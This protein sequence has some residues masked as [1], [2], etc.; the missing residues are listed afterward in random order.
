LV[1]SPIRGSWPE[2]N[3]CLRVWVFGVGR[4][5]WRGGGSVICHSPSL[6]PSAVIRQ[7]MEYIQLLLKNRTYI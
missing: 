2:V 7:Y 3:Y 4:P 6:S 1:S 5:L